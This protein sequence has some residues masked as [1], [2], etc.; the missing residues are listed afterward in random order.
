MSLTILE[1]HIY[2]NTQDPMMD[3]MCDRDPTQSASVNPAT[4]ECS[5]IRV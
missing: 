2:A 4:C 5:E 1:Y 3:C